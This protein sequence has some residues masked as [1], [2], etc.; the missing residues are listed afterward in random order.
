MITFYMDVMPSNSCRI[1][2]GRIFSTLV[3]SQK[4]Y[5][6][7]AALLCFVLYLSPVVANALTNGQSA[8]AVV[9][10]PNLTSGAL[11]DTAIGQFIPTATA[12]DSSG[13]VWVTDT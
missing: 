8:T 2:I 11:A 1:Y 9:G 3:V 12:I 7:F 6:I 10:Q 13:N 4:R 5:V